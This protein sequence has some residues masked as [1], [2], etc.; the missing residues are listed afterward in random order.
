MAHFL[1]LGVTHYPLLAG[2]DEHMAG[3]LRWTLTDPD[4]PA[5]AKDP[6]NWPAPMRTEWGVDDGVAAAAHHRKLLVENLAR[7]RD[8]LD[9]FAPDVMVVWGDDQYE[10]FR[11]EVIPPFCVL[12]YGDVEVNPFEVMTKRGS[13][14]AWG[15]PDD[16]TMTLHGD[17]EGARRLADQLLER[18]FDVAYSY[19][20]RVDSPFP[21]AIANTQLFLDYPRAGRQFPYRMIPITVN[22]YGQHAIARRGGLARFAEIA[23]ERLDPAG[24]SP[25]RCVALGR[26]V[27]QSFADTDLRVALVASSSWSHAFLTDKT[28]HIT[29]DTEADQRLYDL[30]AGGAYA[31]WKETTTAEIVDSGQHEMLNW[32]CLTGAT[33]ELGLDLA[34]SE[35]V[36]TDVFNSN[37]CF[38]VFED[39]AREEQ[40][41]EGSKR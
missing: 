41:M 21:H 31:K 38:A 28:W 19:Q 32:F 20:K 18:G 24:P 33:D 3:L 5:E 40:N 9:E 22:C 15:L 10:N 36:L 35:L 23:E 12:A 2:T 4:I 25:A 30:F 29:P 37:K 7:C 16:T 14:N 8:A 11:E 17:A 27:A 34:W 26:A 1:G 39:H 13:P 6:A